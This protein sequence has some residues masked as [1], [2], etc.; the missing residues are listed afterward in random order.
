VVIEEDFGEPPGAVILK[1]PHDLSK[2]TV[3][4]VASEA[5]VILLVPLLPSEFFAAFKELS[6]FDDLRP[7]IVVFMA[8]AMRNTVTGRDVDPSAC[9]NRCRNEG[10][11]HGFALPRYNDGGLLFRPTPALQIAKCVE[12]RHDLRFEKHLRE[13]V[14]GPGICN[15]GLWNTLAFGQAFE[16]DDPTHAVGG[17]AA[18]SNFKPGNT[19]EYQRD[20]IVSRPVREKKTGRQV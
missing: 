11:L 16:A 13:L 17:V 8:P 5:W 14:N 4:R 18:R 9:W 19:I 6:E 1:R 10:P 20:G 2:E 12:L 7:K 3:L 15:Q